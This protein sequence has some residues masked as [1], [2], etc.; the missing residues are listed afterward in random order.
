[1]DKTLL[2]KQK[3]QVER[4]RKLLDVPTEEILRE[5]SPDMRMLYEKTVLVQMMLN[6]WVLGG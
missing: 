5:L 6:T 2:E 1:M 3:E 4:L